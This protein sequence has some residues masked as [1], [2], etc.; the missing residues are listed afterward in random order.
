MTG[1]REPN[2]INEEI[3]DFKMSL[4]DFFCPKWKHSDKEVRLCAVKVLADPKKI[5]KVAKND[6]DDEVRKVAI[7]KL[8]DQNSLAEIAKSNMSYVLRC[9]AAERLK[10][11]D[12]LVKML[13]EETLRWDDAVF[14]FR[15]EAVKKL[16]DQGTL[17]DIANYAKDERI[18]LEAIGKLEDQA[19]LTDIFKKEI[20]SDIRK[21]IIV[22]IKDQAV[23]ID[24]VNS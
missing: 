11:H 20:S 8:E 5:A 16:K 14:K 3:G 23:L 18:R 9:M 17:A 1:K 22:R 13:K 7:G 15:Q 24:S 12:L 4:L 2:I 21:S 10:N 19:I 6:P